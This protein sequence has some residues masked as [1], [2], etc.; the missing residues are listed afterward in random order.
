MIFSISINNPF[1]EHAS[2]ILENHRAYA[3]SIGVDYIPHGNDLCWEAFKSQYPD[4]AEYD[5]INFYKIY[6]L[7]GYAR[8]YDKV[9]YID[10]DILFNTKENI[11]D[12]HDLS[13]GIYVRTTE[14]KEK[15]I[16]VM[17]HGATLNPKS[18]VSKYITTYKMSNYTIE[19]PV[20]NTGLILGSSDYINKIKFTENIDKMIGLIDSP[21]IFTEEITSKLTYNNEA[22]FRYMVSTNKIP[23]INNNGQWNYSHHTGDEFYP[24]NKVFHMISKEFGRLSWL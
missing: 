4:V 8:D 1:P 15:F 13:K 14:A 24:D 19:D 23:I 21:S 3:K 22:M 9:L 20:I 7:E 16:D 17:N 6:L 11:F 10:F 12:A 18:F 5:V 2:W